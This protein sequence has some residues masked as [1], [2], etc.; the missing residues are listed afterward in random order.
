MSAGAMRD[1]LV[2]QLGLNPAVV[3]SV[4]LKFWQAGAGLLGLVLV[5]LHF[6]PDVQGFYYTFASLVALQSFVELGLY[7]VISNA[8]SHEWS[9]LALRSDGC[10]EGTRWHCPGW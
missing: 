6:A 10:I 3:L 1:Y 9:K 2:R 8:A 4:F 7:I 5:G